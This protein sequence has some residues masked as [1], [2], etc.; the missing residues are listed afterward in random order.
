MSHVYPVKASTAPPMLFRSEAAR[1]AFL[2]SPQAIA[3]E[4]RALKPIPLHEWDENRQKARPVLAN[5]DTLSTEELAR[6][7]AKLRS[8]THG[9]NAS[10]R[11]GAET[12]L[13]YSSSK[14]KD[15]PAPKAYAPR[16]PDLTGATFTTSRPTLKAQ[17]EKR[18]A[19][20][21]LKPGH[22]RVRVR[23]SGEHLPDGTPPQWEAKLTNDGWQITHPNPY[24]YK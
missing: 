16:Y 4:Y 12:T 14:E 24:I 13:V 19:D 8:Y 2:A 15:F 20:P 17:W 18:L 21:A 23:L 1:D 3:H 5:P 11:S 6:T 22:A 7:L 10:K 9:P